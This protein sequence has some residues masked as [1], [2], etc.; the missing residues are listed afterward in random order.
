MKRYSV[1][2]ALAA[3]LLLGG[4]A[5]AASPDPASGA[6]LL[7]Q[8]R[9]ASDIHSSDRWNKD[10]CVGFVSGFVDGHRMAKGSAFCVPVEASTG[11]IVTGVVRYLEDHAETREIPRGEALGA[12]LQDLYPC[13]NANP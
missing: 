2:P 12:A 11:R 3:F 9:K 6:F 4:I 1:V 8:C 5:E 7:E 10:F 13:E